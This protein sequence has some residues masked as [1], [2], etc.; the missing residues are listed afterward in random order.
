MIEWWYLLP[1]AFFCTCLGMFVTSMMVI[2][3]RSAH[4]LKLDLA[5]SKAKLAQMNYTIGCAAKYPADYVRERDEL[6]AHVG[7]LENLLLRE[8]EEVGSQS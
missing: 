3:K 7:R 5:G 2:S 6:A 4:D 1:C 8:R